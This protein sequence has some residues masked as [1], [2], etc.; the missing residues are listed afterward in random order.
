MGFKRPSRASLVMQFVLWLPLVAVNF[1]VAA[2]AYQKQ[3]ETYTPAILI[4]LCINIVLV[5]VH[6]YGLIPNFLQTKKIARY[7]LLLLGLMVVATWL[8]GAVMVVFD[9]PDVPYEESVREASRV[10]ALSTIVLMILTLPLLAFDRLLEREKN[11]QKLQR[12]ALE[13]E[14]ELLRAQLNPHFLFN[15]LNNIYAMLVTGISGAEEAVLKLSDLSRFMLYESSDPQIALVKEMRYL[16][17]FIDLHVLKKEQ[18]KAIDIRFNPVPENVLLPPLLLLPFFENA[19]KFG[20]W[21]SSRE[22]GWVKG[23]IAVVDRK[24]QFNLSNSV[25]VKPKIYQSGGIG[26]LNVQKRL[27]LHFPDRHNLKII[28]SENQFDVNLSINLNA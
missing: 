2:M 23:E 21:N 12:K 1:W 13:A 9:A 8:K 26:L 15:S 16:Q 7:I 28:R 17:N 25:G 24:L 11:E 27:Q 6:L 5:N 14:V 10:S 4:N 18:R 22:G 20:N 3:V 19:L